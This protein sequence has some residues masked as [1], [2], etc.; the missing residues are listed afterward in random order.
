MPKYEFMGD[1]ITFPAEQQV[2]GAVFVP[3]SYEG[4]KDE[5]GRFHGQG[6]VSLINGSTYNG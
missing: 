6:K 1:T 4:E 5:Q 3:D 2:A